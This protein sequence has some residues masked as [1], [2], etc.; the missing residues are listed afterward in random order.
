MDYPFY[1]MSFYEKAT[2]GAVLLT[3]WAGAYFAVFLGLLTFDQSVSGDFFWNGVAEL[4]NSTSSDPD[5][6]ARAKMISQTQIICRV[7]LFVSCASLLSVLLNF[8][9]MSRQMDK[10]KVEQEMTRQVQGQ[11][12]SLCSQVQRCPNQY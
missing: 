5:R 6:S 1:P 7:L 11:I 4:T 8:V 12:S 2:L 9:Y 10:A 3:Q